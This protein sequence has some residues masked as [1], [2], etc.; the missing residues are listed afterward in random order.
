MNDKVPKEL[1]E[2]QEKQRQATIKKVQNAI[3]AL[4]SEGHKVSIKL[5][6]ECT[7]L[8]RSVFGKTHIRELLINVGV[9]EIQSD[10]AKFQNKAK[11]TEQR[12][13]ER[14]KKQEETIKQLREEKSELQRE[15]ELLR[16]R[17]YELKGLL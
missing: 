10:K 5:L 14:I 15:C 17:V 16:G 12:L 9:I 1:Q 3:D 8:S 4:N 7:G 11:T 13:R 2:R 6:M